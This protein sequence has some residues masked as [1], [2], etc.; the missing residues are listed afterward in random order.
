MATQS[1]IHQRIDISLDAL[2]AN[3]ADLPEVAEEWQALADGERAAWSLDW[4]H[5]MADYLTEL[6][7]QYRGGQ[8]TAKQRTRYRTLLDGLRAA[9]PLIERL[10]LYRPPV[11]LAAEPGTSRSQRRGPRAGTVGERA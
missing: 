6:D 4:D 2:L 7:G 8:M 1:A 11:S 10:D 5:L 3:T 9:L